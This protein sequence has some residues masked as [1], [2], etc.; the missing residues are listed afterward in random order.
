MG[1]DIKSIQELFRS[2]G[3]SG[4]SDI[5]AATA[6]AAGLQRQA[7]QDQSAQIARQAAKAASQRFNMMQQETGD[8]ISGVMGSRALLE[9]TIQNQMM[10]SMGQARLG[11]ASA[12]GNLGLNSIAQQNALKMGAA[13]N[14]AN[15]LQLKMQQDELNRPP[16]LTEV[17]GTALGAGAQVASAALMGSSKKVKTKI[18]SVDPDEELSD[19]KKLKIRNYEYKEGEGPAGKMT[20]ILIEEA[21]EYANKEMNGI[22]LAGVYKLTS[23]NT[24][25][26]QALEK[27]LSELTKG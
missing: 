18:A 26:I 3:D 9:N 13:Q 23:K 15:L 16:G 12:I 14:Q 20:G 24:A 10:E 25:A 17:L 2:I 1:L 5:A 8:D 4:S 21:P 7:L 27:K 19:I 11:A 6:E 22:D